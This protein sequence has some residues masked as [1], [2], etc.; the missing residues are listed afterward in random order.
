MQS[1]MNNPFIRSFF[2][3]NYFYGICAIALSI[4]ATLQQHFT[5]NPPLF[6]LAVFAITVV[7]Y[8]RA[9]I[10]EI[11]IHTTN[12]RSLWYEKNKRFVFWSQ[13]TLTIFVLVLLFLFIQ[14]DWNAI[15]N[16]FPLEIV[17]MLVFP[18]VGLLYYGV[19]GT[20]YSLRNIGWLKPFVIGFAWAG[21]VTIYP[22]IF[23]C[24]HH[25]QPYE[26]TLIGGLL[27]LKNFMFV[28]V[29]CIMFDIKDYASD[30]GSRLNTFVVKFGLRK[31]IFFIIL[32]LCVIGLGTF[33]FYGITKHFHPIKI[34]LNVL[35]FLL[36]ILTAYSLYS[37][38]SL[39]YYLAVVD[40]LM[41]VKGICGTVAILYF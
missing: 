38:R 32:P 21:L 31:T 4:E 25:D 37:R 12:E 16:S 17:L 30:S 33:V 20:R 2:Y 10:T 39:L 36:L 8:S 11:N 28:S 15:L 14:E 13:A 41:L 23:H 7:Y 9:Y 5:L 6:Y 18:L 1:L 3:G 19:S 40:G 22:I 27:F 26:L 35:P 34:T 29:L 24:I